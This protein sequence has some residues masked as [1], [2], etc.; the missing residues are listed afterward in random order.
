MPLLDDRLIEH[1]EVTN[2]LMELNSK[3][4]ENEGHLVTSLKAIQENLEKLFARQGD[5]LKTLTESSEKHL[6]ALKTELM[7]EIHKVATSVTNFATIGED[8]VKKNTESI[9]TL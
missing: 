8:V 6:E 9:K 7:G 5:K 2:N 4:V 3:V 1:Q